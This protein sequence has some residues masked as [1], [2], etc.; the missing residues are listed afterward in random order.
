MDNGTLRLIGLML[1][2]MLGGGLYSLVMSYFTKNNL[3]RFLPSLAGI[4]LI[5]YLIYQMYYGNLE[6]FMPLA[7][8]LFIFMILSIIIGNV[9]ANII[10]NILQKR[11]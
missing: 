1:L 8:L 5:P 11:K 9:L 7:Y 4:I 2:F 6:G 10:V 3:L